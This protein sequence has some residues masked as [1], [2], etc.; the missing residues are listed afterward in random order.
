MKWVTNKNL[1]SYKITN[2]YYLANKLLTRLRNII[3]HTSVLKEYYTQLEKTVCFFS[4][5]ICENW[6]NPFGCCFSIMKW[7]ILLLIFFSMCYK[8]N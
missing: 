8:F 5:D 7:N 1:P 4:W 6:V 3:K 2:L